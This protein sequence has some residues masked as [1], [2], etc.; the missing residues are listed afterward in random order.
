MLYI[1]FF[2]STG[3]PGN[4]QV[5]QPGTMPPQTAIPP[6]YTP[7]SQP[8][9]YQDL[10]QAGQQPPP[11][12]PEYQPYAPVYQGSNMAGGSLPPVHTGI[13]HKN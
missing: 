5:V 7:A 8:P 12:N 4:Q 11:Q 1:S 9:A 13:P 10:R 3:M 6:N 2:L